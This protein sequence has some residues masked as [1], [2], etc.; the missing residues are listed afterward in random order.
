[1]DGAI[2]PEVTASAH[3]DP[4]TSRCDIDAGTGAG[5]GLEGSRTVAPG[6]PV[7]ISVPGRGPRA[8]PLLS[9]IGCW[10]SAGDDGT[11]GDRG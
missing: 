11:A 1:M 5:P 8:S 7:R 2:V 10:E 4:S 3:G 6:T 9:L